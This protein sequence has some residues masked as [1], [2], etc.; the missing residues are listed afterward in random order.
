MKKA[1]QELKGL[2]ADA[3]ALG[4]IV[5]NDGKLKTTPPAHWEEACGGTFVHWVRIL[6]SS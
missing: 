3:G 5:S 4:I 2:S 6:H 1:A